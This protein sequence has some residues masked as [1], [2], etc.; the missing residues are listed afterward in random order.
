MSK[1]PSLVRTA[2]AACTVA[3][4]FL[5]A[6]CAPSPRPA[7]LAG[8][9][10][11]TWQSTANDGGGNVSATFTHEGST[12]R[13]SVTLTGSPC[14]ETG[15]IN[16]TIDGQGVSFGAIGNDDEVRFAGRLTGDNK[17]AGTY[18]VSAGMCAGD[19]GQ[20]SVTRIPN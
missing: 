6:A 13:G 1:P 5:L 17:L 11:G 14:L 19:N 4:F 15:T 16:G 8:N 7:S 18:S 3:A 10:S 20:F 2:R 12:L 9:W